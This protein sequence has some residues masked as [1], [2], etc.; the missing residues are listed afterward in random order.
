[1][2]NRKYHRRL[3]VW[4]RYAARC[5]RLVT[6]QVMADVVRCPVRTTPGYF[7]AEGWKT[8]ADSAVRHGC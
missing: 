3:L 7:R 6:G 2:S 5:E 4:K 1:M 8:G